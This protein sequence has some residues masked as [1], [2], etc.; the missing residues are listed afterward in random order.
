MS[1][2]F[3]PRDRVDELVARLLQSAE[4]IA[5]K[6]VETGDVFYSPVSSP[7]EVAWDYKTAVEP[8]KR[9]LFPQRE[10]IL[11]FSREE[12]KLK[13]E[14]VLEGKERIF[15][16]VRGCDVTGVAVLDA[17]FGGEIEDP[18]YLAQRQR[19]TFI[20]LAC[21]EADEHCFCVCGDA[22]PFLKNG[23]DQQ[24][25]PLAEGMLIEVGSEKG[26]A[27]AD[28]HQDLLSPAE[29]DQVA[30]KLQ[31][32][33]KAEE[34]FG[35]FRSYIA[36]AMRRLTMAETPD[37]VWEKLA[38]NCVEC[39][40]CTFLC[41]TC[42]CFTVTSREE[43]DGGMLERQWDAC[44]Y[45]CYAREASGHNPRGEHPQRLRARFFHKLSHQ[46]AQRNGRHACVGC[47]R[48]VVGCQA[49]AH[50][51]AATEAIRRG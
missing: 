27:L 50:M 8:L 7:A 19:A 9:F 3:L 35:E 49:W 43:G 6:R 18:Y 10:P 39:G 47:G 38:D 12:G 22:G 15:L 26:Q 21:L 31:L 16:G 48:C 42:S 23:Y 34:S 13:V 30:E 51:S 11:Q 40:G 36:A 4:V 14:A 25:T 2:Y 45:P 17:M 5:P 32:A 41:P 44:L 20:A 29:P 33:K 46:W 37:E 28:A 1:S 24:W